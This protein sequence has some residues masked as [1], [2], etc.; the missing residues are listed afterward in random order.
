MPAMKMIGI[1]TESEFK[2]VGEKGVGW[3]LA[4]GKWRL[5]KTLAISFLSQLHSVRG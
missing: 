1:E 4:E 3:G 2:L 5:E